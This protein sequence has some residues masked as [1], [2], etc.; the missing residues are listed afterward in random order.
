MPKPHPTRDKFLKYLRQQLCHDT[1][2]VDVSG[3]YLA[4]DVRN[5]IEKIRKMDPL[6][7]KILNYYVKTRNPRMRIAEA[8]HYDSSTVKRK[9]DDAVDLV[10]SNM[11]DARIAD[12]DQ[13]ED[14]AI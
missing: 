9:L 6:L 7:Y 10:M 13:D 8:V 12:P 14:E 5:A 2:W 1:P 11:K 4:E 3:V